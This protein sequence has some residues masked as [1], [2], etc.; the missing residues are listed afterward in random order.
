MD[1]IPPTPLTVRYGPAAVLLQ[2]RTD[3]STDWG[4][5]HIWARTRFMHPVAHT[6]GGA[7]S[8]IEIRPVFILGV[9]RGATAY[10]ITCCQLFATNHAGRYVGRSGT[11]G[12]QPVVGTYP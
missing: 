10:T 12:T 7:N 3:G 9:Q 5:R 2:F 1:S 4:N 8:A 6:G 11:P